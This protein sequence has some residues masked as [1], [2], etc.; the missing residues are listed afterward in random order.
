M[1]ASPVNLTSDD[2]SIQPQLHSNLVAIK[3]RQQNRTCKWTYNDKTFSST[4]S[5]EVTIP[6][7]VCNYLYQDL[8]QEFF[9][10]IEL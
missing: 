3:E 1:S 6:K 7:T 5:L 10:M 2:A 9:T 8:M 4:R